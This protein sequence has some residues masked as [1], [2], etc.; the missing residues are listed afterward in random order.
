MCAGCC[1]PAPPE[2]ML[3]VTLVCWPI[4]VNVTAPPWLASRPGPKLRV[5][6][7][8]AEAVAA[9]IVRAAAA[10]S[11]ASLRTCFSGLLAS[12]C[13]AVVRALGISP[14]MVHPYYDACT[15]TDCGG[16]HG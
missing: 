15:A 12:Y 9:L 6:G 2:G 5:S 7:V 14:R 8:C 4:G 3:I 10:R 11:T 16:R 1:T 13:R